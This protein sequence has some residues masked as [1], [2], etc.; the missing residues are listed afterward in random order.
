LKP[1][2]EVGSWLRHHGLEREQA[3]AMLAA[4][5]AALD[6]RQLT[7]EGLAGEV[8]RITRIAGLDG[9]LRGGFGDLLKPAAF[10]GDFCFAPSDGR[11]VRFARPDQWLGEWEP[12]AVDEAA[13]AVTRRYLAAYG[14]ANRQALARWFGMPSPTLAGRWL[15]E[16]GDEAA[17]VEVDGEELVMLA[18]DVEEA[19]AAEPA[20]SVRLL[21]A[22]DHY[23]VAAPRDRDAVLPG[24]QRARV[25]RPQG[26]LSPVLLVDGRMA[27]VWA[28]E[29]EGDRLVVEIEPFGRLPHAVR[30]GA[31]AEAA[32][33]AD[34]LGG[35]LQLSFTA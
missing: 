34:F 25:Y 1:R 10:R 13:R 24:D 28:H 33:L 35:E 17:P 32:A 4:I 31:E 14:P 26:W 6:G 12:V 8:A 27:G 18:A 3:E 9:K 7:R 5:P 23:V 29:R 2:Y 30:A 22:F 19:A 21:P 15:K 11:N 20:E 16:L